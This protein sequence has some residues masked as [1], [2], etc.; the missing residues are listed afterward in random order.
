MADTRRFSTSEPAVRSD[1]ARA[2][3][4]RPLPAASA[5]QCS[6]ISISK[7]PHARMAGKITWMAFGAERRRGV[8]SARSVHSIACSYWQG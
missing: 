2:A 6:T 1:D 4:R 8:A 5:Q 7:A 3:P